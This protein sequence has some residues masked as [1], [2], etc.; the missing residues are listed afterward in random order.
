MDKPIRVPDPPATMTAYFFIL[1]IFG[2]IRNMHQFK[3]SLYLARVKIF[4]PLLMVFA[5]VSCTSREAKQKQVL[6]LREMSELATVEYTVT[7]MIKASDDQTWYKIGDRK[8]LM[9]CRAT[10]KAGIDFSRIDAQHVRIKDKEVSIILPRAKLIS[11][12]IRPEDIKVEYQDIGI[13][14][15]DF[16]AQDRDQLSAQGESQIRSGASALGI[17][18]TAETNASLFVGQFL[19]KLGYEKVNVQFDDPGNLPKLN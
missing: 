6:A 14:R 11:V 15:S 4:A 17:L 1:G 13:L 2:K 3:S 18:A 12:N 9:S 5:M 19:R 16:N 7:K 10:L 8:I